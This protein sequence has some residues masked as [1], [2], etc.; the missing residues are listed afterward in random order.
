M[1]GLRELGLGPKVEEENAVPDA[2]EE[3]IEIGAQL[4][5][6]ENK[7]RKKLLR[8]LPLRHKM[9]AGLPLHRLS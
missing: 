3:I 4:P 6:Q 5:V 8:V 9:R 7:L 1:S 2:G